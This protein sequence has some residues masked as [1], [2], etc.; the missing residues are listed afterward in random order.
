MVISLILL[1]NGT[2]ELDYKN[3]YLLNEY[4]AREVLFFLRGVRFELFALIR[5]KFVCMKCDMKRKL[6][7]FFAKI[8]LILSVNNFA[9]P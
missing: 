8:E 7:S 2:A 5:W 3:S 4:S 6:F 1:W 9:L